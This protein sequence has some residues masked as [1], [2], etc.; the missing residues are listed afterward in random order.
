MGVGS[1]GL[2]VINSKRRVLRVESPEPEFQAISSKGR[3]QGA[4]EKI[5]LSVL[6]SVVSSHSQRVGCRRFAHSV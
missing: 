3:R 2:R 5:V 6:L 1:L 4:V